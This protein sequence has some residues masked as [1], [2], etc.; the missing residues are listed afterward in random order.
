MREGETMYSATLINHPFG[1]RGVY[2]EC[3]YRRESPLF[4]LGELYLLPPRKL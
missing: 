1:D 3:K 4:A 2:M